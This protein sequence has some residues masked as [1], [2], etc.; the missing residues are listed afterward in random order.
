LTDELKR[1][2]HNTSN[3]LKFNLPYI[4][5]Y[6]YTVFTKVSL[7]KQ[8]LAVVVYLLS[9]YIVS[10]LKIIVSVYRFLPNKGVL[11]FK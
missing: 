9:H 11:D 10:I 1:L 7:H 3:L 2:Q 6:T 8:V 4:Y 5:I